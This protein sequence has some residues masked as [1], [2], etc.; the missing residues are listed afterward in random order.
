MRAIFSSRDFTARIEHPFDFSVDSFEWTL[1]GGPYLAELTAPMNEDT[2]DA[3]SLLR[4]PVQIIGEDSEP[5]WWGYVNEVKIPGASFT[6]GVSLEYMYNRVRVT[7]ADMPEDESS[8]S[9]QLNTSYADAVDSQNIFGIR[10]Y[11]HQMGDGNAASAEAT[12]NRILGENKYPVPTIDPYKSTQISLK[13]RGWFDT[14]DW[15][16]YSNSGETNV[17]TTTQIGTILAAKGQF[18]RGT[19]V[20]NASGINTNEFRDGQTT[21]KAQVEDLLASGTSA[22]ERLYGVVNVERY[23]EIRKIASVTYPDFRLRD[24]GLLETFADVPFSA[25]RIKDAIGKWAS[26]KSAPAVIGNFSVIRP[27]LIESATWRKQDNSATYRPLGQAD[28]LKVNFSG[29]F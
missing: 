15:Q 9:Q 26:V 25:E 7:Y 1:N 27:F 17:Q 11:T 8:P 24:D 14:L 22:G 5:I 16:H 13:L 19:H 6:L 2:W 21:V 20:F 18:I 23:L 29:A 10:E 28:M 12:R 4:C 3:A